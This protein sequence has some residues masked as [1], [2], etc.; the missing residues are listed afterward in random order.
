MDADGSRRLTLGTC[1]R[2]GRP[3][4]LRRR[5]DL[6]L[7][8]APTIASWSTIRQRRAAEAVPL[9]L[10]FA[11]VRPDLD[12]RQRALLPG[13]AATRYADDES[14]RHD[15]E[16]T[17]TQNAGA[18]DESRSGRRIPQESGDDGHPGTGDQGPLDVIVRIGGAGV[19]RT[20]LHI[21]EGQWAEKSGVTLPYTIGHEN[22]GWVHAVGDAVTNV[23]GR[24]QGDPAP[25]GHLRA[26]PRLPGR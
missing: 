2:Q 1:P 11:E 10:R 22:A 15:R 23:G 3:A 26:V 4:L 21:L 17:D 20:D 16:I 18:R 25:A 13:P 14:A 5:V 12:R 19:C 9:Q 6:G 24:R 7:S 8:C